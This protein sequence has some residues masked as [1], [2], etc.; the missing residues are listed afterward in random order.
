MAV[1]GL[2]IRNLL[3]GGMLCVV[4]MGFYF[5][6]NYHAQYR[7][8]NQEES[9]P[10]K[11]EPR[12]KDNVITIPKVEIKSLRDE[13][14]VKP[15]KEGR[16]ISK[17]LF[18][19]T[20]SDR[21]L[22]SATVLAS[23][24]RGEGFV[25][26][27]THAMYHCDKNMDTKSSNNVERLTFRDVV[28]VEAEIKTSIHPHA[29]K[30][31]LESS[32]GEQMHDEDY[33]ML[34]ES[35]SIFLKKPTI[36]IVREQTTDIQHPKG[37]GQDAAFYVP[38][39]PLLPK[40][41]IKEVCG[42]ESPAMYI[43]DWRAFA[44]EPPYI[45]Q[46]QHLQQMIAVYVSFWDKLGDGDKHLAYPLA[47]GH[48][49]MENGVSGSFRISKYHS[50]MENWDF[51]DDLTGNPCN[52]TK[53]AGKGNTY[54]PFTLQAA[55][56][57]LNQ[58]P[59][60]RG[61]QFSSSLVP[62]DII[63][64]DGW[65]LQEPPEA[66]WDQ[67]TVTKGDEG[68]TTI[69][70][71]RHAFSVCMATRQ[72]NSALTLYRQDACPLGFNTNKRLNVSQHLYP[73][74]RESSLPYGGSKPDIKFSFYG[75]YERE[76]EKPIPPA[77]S[78]GS[79]DIHFVFTTTCTGYQHWQSENLMHSALVVDQPG[80][81][82]RILSACTHE[83]TMEVLKRGSSNPKLGFHVVPDYKD[84]PYPNITDNNYTPYNKPFGI[85]HWLRNANPPVKESLVVIID[86]DFFFL[87]PFH[88]N[89]LMKERIAYSG[90]RDIAEINDKVE[91]G[92]AVAQNWVNYLGAL[93]FTK[94]RQEET[95]KLC[96]TGPECQVSEADAKEYFSVGPPYALFRNDLES[97]IDDYCNITVG[98]RQLHPDHW[99]SEM[100]GYS[101]ASAK[102]SV[103][104]TRLDNLAVT[105]AA[106]EYWGFVDKL[107]E[108]P[109]EDP[110][111]PLIP[112][113]APYFIHS[114][115]KYEIVLP[116]GFKWKF[117]KQYM[118]EDMY[119]C[120]SWLLE[121]APAEV[122]TVAKKSL[123]K[124]D[125]HQAYGLCTLIKLMN[126]SLR[127][128]KRDHCPNGFNSNKA[129]RLVSPRP[130]SFLKIGKNQMKW[131]E[132]KDGKKW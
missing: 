25:D 91:K 55:N 89:T 131:T 57:T 2:N 127:R 94:D 118:P 62:S 44:I 119:A 109:C 82:T 114:C 130:A 77:G 101:M 95:K 123:D 64:C 113:D 72:Y 30:R 47:L 13:N 27:I 111:E 60:G 132:K 121:P 21:D 45:I 63:G 112:D 117:Y 122:W 129:L 9:R 26:G 84:H 39:M 76:E 97:F 17:I 71:R 124:K 110:V 34:V 58:W 88:V 106:D 75:D 37:Y 35:D 16:D 14:V 120:D 74:G 116:F 66:L 3:L 80:R 23:S 73:T 46:K 92:T 10:W 31:W 128:Y 90:R 100:Y 15:E 54:Y 4:L 103:K 53:S 50:R 70:R 86:P 105:L 28:P 51:S 36:D 81:F 22:L 42:R 98:M 108:N 69:L 87:R 12:H 79:E 41:I 104:H 6:L 24:A 8:Y 85:R 18:T 99:M 52:A 40:E 49:K 107:E 78:F 33:V 83:Q 43:D 29:V 126:R 48:M 56:L 93:A 38:Q 96:G 20:C 68:I 65:L 7:S 32:N 61:Y 5:N 67:A 19:T 11:A 1:S 115:I 102:H 59:D 125:L